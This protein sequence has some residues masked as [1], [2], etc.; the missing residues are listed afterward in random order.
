[1]AV[2]PPER[3]RLKDGR[4]VE[5]RPIEPAD[6]GSLQEGLEELSSD[7]RYQR[8][9]APKRGF[10]SS[11]LAYLTGV[12]H[13]AHEA[14]VAHEPGTDRGLGVARF[15]QDPT[16]PQCAELA[17]VV[18][19]EWQGRGLGGALLHRL[20]DRAAQEGVRHFTASILESNHDIVALL[21]KVGPVDARHPG[22]GVAELTIH[23]HE[24]EPCPPVIREALRAA[25]RG[26]LELA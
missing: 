8:F 20:A 2:Q 11:E 13:S 16:D 15:V 5:I 19:D 18:T 9:L 21:R 10:S 6:A 26:E 22:G 7:S 3:V 25:A 1:M 14:L 17:I 4:E 23:L 24:G 12:D